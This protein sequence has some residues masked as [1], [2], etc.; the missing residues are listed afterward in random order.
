MPYL[1]H[2]ITYCSHRSCCGDLKDSGKHRNRRSRCSRPP[3]HEPKKLSTPV[4]THRC[5]FSNIG[6]FE[7]S[8]FAF[9]CT[10]QRHAEE[11]Q[12]L[13][14]SYLV[15]YM[16]LPPWLR[17]EPRGIDRTAALLESNSLRL[18]IAPNSTALPSSS[19]RG[20]A[21]SYLPLERTLCC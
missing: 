21:H 18:Y 14:A 5:L 10:Y 19:S 6:I 7:L 17:S 9:G 20:S 8:G 1:L 3:V 15:L 2:E 4:R 12:E 11:A 16:H 13:Q